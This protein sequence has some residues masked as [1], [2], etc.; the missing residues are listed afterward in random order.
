MV[1]LIC[2]IIIIII[3]IIMTFILLLLRL[4]SSR[5]G[6]SFGKIPETRKYTEILSLCVFGVVVNSLWM[7]QNSNEYELVVAFYPD[8]RMKHQAHTQGAR[9]PGR[10]CRDCKICEHYVNI[11][12]KHCRRVV[13]MSRSVILVCGKFDCFHGVVA[14]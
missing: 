12:A 6:A 1:F 7:V 13:S 8:F 11:M 9:N 3:S 5:V 4:F 14:G 2:F 10:R